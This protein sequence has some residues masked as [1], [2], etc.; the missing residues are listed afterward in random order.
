MKS[1]MKHQFSINPSV[2]MPRSS[3]DRSFGHKLTGDAGNLIPFYVD[4]VLPGDTFSLQTTGF[5]RLATPLF[6]FMDNMYLDT[7]FFFVPYRLVWDNARKFFGEQD[8]PGDSIDY[9]LPIMTAHVPAE[10]SL[11]DYLGLMGATGAETVEHVSLY[12]RGYN[13]V[14]NHWFRPEQLINSV[15]VD[16]DDGPDA[17]A[18]YTL[19]KR[20]KRHDYFTSCL[21]A[22]QRGAAVSLPLGSTAPV[23]G[24]GSDSQLYVGSPATV[25]ESGG[26]SR[27]YTNA[28]DISTGTV[29]LEGTAG[30]GGYPTIYADLTNATASSINDFREAIQ[31]QRLLEKDSRGSTRYPDLVRNHFG[32][33][34]YDLAVR[35]EFLGG[36]STPVKSTPVSQNAPTTAGSQVGIGDLSAFATASFVD[37]GFTK[38]FNE[39]GFV[40][41]LLSLRADLTYQQGIHRRYLKST[42]YDIFWPTLAHLGEQAVYQGELYYQNHSTDTDGDGITDNMEVFGYNPRFDEYRYLPSQLS[43]AFRS[44]A[45]TPLDAWHLSQEFSSLP[46]LGQTFIEETPPVDRIIQVPAEPHFILDTYTK[47]RCARPMPLYAVPGMIDRF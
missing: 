28:R 8:N 41:G 42:R 31:I 29:W 36:G 21:P 2:E 10:G 9:S 19:L 32:V 13:L 44:S 25:Y 17:I 5:A 14:Y 27:A 23:K 34:F 40:L 24:I 11:S 6:P 4:D 38:S 1:V 12:H 33:D 46:S 22:P 43:G 7:H 26:T 35:P 45:A 47:L 15:V 16:T 18:D 3:F 39:H 37:H 30:A 20:A